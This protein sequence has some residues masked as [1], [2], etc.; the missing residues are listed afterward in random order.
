MSQLEN[1]LRSFAAGSGTVAALQLAAEQTSG[2]LGDRT[3]ALLTEYE[4]SDYEFDEIELR[5]RV[6]QL[7]NE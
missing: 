2:A 4:N 6:A 5:R 7:L 3:L 1:F